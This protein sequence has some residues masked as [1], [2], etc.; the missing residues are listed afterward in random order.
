MKSVEIKIN[1][2]MAELRIIHR[3]GDHILAEVDGRRYELDLCRLKEGVY[4]ILTDGKSYNIDL[5]QQKSFKDYVGHTHYSTYDI[6]IIDA[7][8]KYLQ[9]KGNKGGD[10]SNIISSPMPGKVVRIPAKE[11]E[12][13][14][15]GE[16]AIVVSAMKMESEYKVNSDKKVVRIMVKEGDIIE[17]NQPLVILE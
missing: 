4:S 8:A 12:M 10:D 5:V 17:G 13:L 7:E 6:S 16:T 11:G 1:G 3:K 9:A 14:K 2:R 15:E